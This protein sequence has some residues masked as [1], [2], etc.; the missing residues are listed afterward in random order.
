MQIQ[1]NHLHCHPTLPYHLPA[2]LSLCFPNFSPLVVYFATKLEIT[3]KSSLSSNACISSCIPSSEIFGKNHTDALKLK[4]STIANAWLLF[5]GH[6]SFPLCLH[7]LSLSLSGVSVAHDGFLFY[8]PR[9][10]FLLCPPQLT[11]NP[12]FWPLPSGSM[13]LSLAFLWCSCAPLPLYLCTSVPSV[14]PWPLSAPLLGLS[15]VSARGN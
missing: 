11:F 15:V 14:P 12:P 5:T 1:K 4:K 10:L 9:Q 7:L 8:L 3:E 2:S 13:H 6:L